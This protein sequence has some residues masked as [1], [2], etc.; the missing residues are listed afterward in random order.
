MR[1][2]KPPDKIN[3]RVGRVQT[4]RRRN[5]STKI[6]AMARNL[7]PEEPLIGSL[8]LDSHADTTVFGKN[9]LVIGYTGRECDVMPYTDTYES[10]KGVPIVTAATAWTC[11]DSG[12]TYILVF[13]EGLWMGETMENSLINPN[14]LRAFG[15]IVQDNP[16]SGSPLYIEDPEEEVIIPLETQGT[17]IQTTT[18]TPSQQELDECPHIVFTSQREWEPTKVTFPAPK[19][20]IAEE[21]AGRMIGMVDTEQQS[22]GN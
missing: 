22:N 3:L 8:E 13:H 7:A 16:F 14:Q 18:R 12:R 20:T 21:K 2:K 10:V 5:R 17:N 11:L 4:M 9:F 15:C 1:D 19:W 6:G